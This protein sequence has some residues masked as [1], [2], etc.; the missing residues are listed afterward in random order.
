MSGLSGVVKVSGVLRRPTVD[1]MNR[2]LTEV[3]AL[4]FGVSRL[5]GFKAVVGKAVGS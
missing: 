4:G 1:S 5:G 2:V 3:P